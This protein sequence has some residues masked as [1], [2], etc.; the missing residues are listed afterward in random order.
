MILTTAIFPYTHYAVPDLMHFST[1]SCLNDL[2]V[3]CGLAWLYQ[4]R[5]ELLVSWFARRKKPVLIIFYSLFAIYLVMWAGVDYTNPWGAVADRVIVS[6]GFAFIL[7]EQ[8]MSPHSILKLRHSGFLSKLGTIT[9]GLYC[10]HYIFIGLMFTLLSR[11]H[12]LPQVPAFIVSSLLALG[13]TILAGRLSF[14]YYEN[15]FLGLKK[16]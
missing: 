9:Y 5:Q 16:Y 3:G 13:G 8:I 7:A 1:L 4:H 14:R 11:S 2:A 12:V 10:Y 6:L 15:Y